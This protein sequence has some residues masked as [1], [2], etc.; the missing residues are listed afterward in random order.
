MKH[1]HA[2]IHGEVQG[3][4]LRDFIRSCAKKLRLNGTVKNL[5]D[6]TV[7]VIAEGDELL[8]KACIESVK[9]DYP[10]ASVTRIDE[11]WGEQTGLFPDF[12]I[13]RS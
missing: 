3:V 6:G 9:K 12:R 1:L 5:P 8:L 7:E 11:V 4:S 10:F 2:I 13:L